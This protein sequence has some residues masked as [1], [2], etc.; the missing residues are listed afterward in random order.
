MGEKNTLPG[1]V[2]NLNREAELGLFRANLA[3]QGVCPSGAVV[4]SGPSPVSLIKR[5]VPRHI[6]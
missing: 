3:L 6:T 5:G 4:L 2:S 1:I